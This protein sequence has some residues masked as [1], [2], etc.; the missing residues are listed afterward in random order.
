[1]RGLPPC[2]PTKILW[3]LGGLPQRESCANRSKILM[4]RAL[5]TQRHYSPMHEKMHYMSSF[6]VLSNPPIAFRSVLFSMQS[7]SL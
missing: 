5:N 2:K 1:M 4:T 7:G 6:S 3:Y